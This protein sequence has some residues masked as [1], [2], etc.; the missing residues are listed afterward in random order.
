MNAPPSFEQKP[1][2]GAIAPFRVKECVVGMDFNV[3]V[4]ALLRYLNFF[5]AKIPVESVHFLHVL[6]VPNLFNLYGE[7]N[8]ITYDETQ[9]NKEV[10]EKLQFQVSQT[11]TSI[12]HSR[13]KIDVKEGNPL[14]TLIETAD[15]NNADLVLIGHNVTQTHHGVLT[16]NFARQVRSNALMVPSKAKN[17]LKKILIPVDFSQNSAAALRTGIAINNQL[18]KPAKIGLVHTYHLPANFSAYRFNESKVMEMLEEDRENAL[19]AFIEDHVPKDDRSRIDPILLKHNHYS[20]GHHIASFAENHK[21]DLI[22]MGAKGHSK[23]SLM[24]MGSVTEKV[25]SLTK[26]IPVLVVK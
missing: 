2:S 12:E 6:P 16:K 20:I 7:E 17:S 5:A 3:S 11:I 14:E 24:L 8:A 4:E 9:V 13:F 21:F 26:K 23:V 25:L 1:N 19:H 22:I 15:A 18:E 10:V